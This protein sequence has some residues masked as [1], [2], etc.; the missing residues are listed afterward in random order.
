MENL[1]YQEDIWDEMLDGRVVAMSPRPVV[2]H[3]RV[4]ANI[5][6]IFRTFLKG[7]LCEAFGDGVDV[8]LTKK[9][10]VI[11]DVMVVCDKDIIRKDGVHGAPDLIAEVLSPSTAARDK[12]YKKK[13]YERC[14]V[15]EYWLV[16]ADS[17][18][19]EVYWLENGSY[20]LKD[21]YSVFPD[22]FI[23]KMSEEEKAAI[24]YEFKTS[25]FEDLTVRIEDVFEG[26]L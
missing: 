6:S 12:G 18:S 16:D 20:E 10:R 9:D 7:K 23:G 14:G 4:S 24:I 13:L 19:I 3:N 5:Y 15:R 21:V 8:Y 1:A 22:Y 26:I 17:R 2:N 11:P 25:L